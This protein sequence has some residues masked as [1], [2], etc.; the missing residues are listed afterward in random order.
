MY[1]QFIVLNKINHLNFNNNE[2]KTC[3]YLSWEVITA[4][5]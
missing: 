2:N 4:N 1:R 5:M 3:K